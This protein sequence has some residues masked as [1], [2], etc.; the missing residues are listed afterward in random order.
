MFAKRILEA[1]IRDPP[2]ASPMPYPA[3]PLVVACPSLKYK[4]S[5]YH[6]VSWHLEDSM[7]D[8]F[9]QMKSTQGEDPPGDN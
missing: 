5:G 9:I 8:P 7:G 1:S 2:Q 3:P 6:F 4:A